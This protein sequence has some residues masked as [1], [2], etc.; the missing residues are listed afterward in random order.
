[1]PDETTKAD[2]V[3]V[4]DMIPPHSSLSSLPDV[5]DGGVLPGVTAR[6]FIRDAQ[7]EETDSAVSLLSGVAVRPTPMSPVQRSPRAKARSHSN[8]FH[9]PKFT[10]N[11]G[12]LR[13][14]MVS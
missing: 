1:M 5:D 2:F 13:S 8:L 6:G 11:A 4:E 9:L 7:S 3:D 12:T 10:C 14:D